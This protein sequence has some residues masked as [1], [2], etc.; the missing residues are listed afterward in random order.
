[1]NKKII[2]NF[3]E[4]SY[5]QI[6]YILKKKAL[7]G[8]YNNWLKTN[9]LSLENYEDVYQWCNRITKCG[10]KYHIIIEINYN[11][12][13]IQYIF[14]GHNDGYDEYGTNYSWQINKTWL[15]KDFIN[16]SNDNKLLNYYKIFFKDSDIDL[17]SNTNSIIEFIKNHSCNDK[18]RMRFTIP[19]IKKLYI[20]N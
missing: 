20:N 3:Q 18:I 10:E 2:L 4:I 19:D 12:D 17:M 11:H 7:D 16:K 14:I 15:S 9:N 5:I 8:I 13:E 1:M 6:D